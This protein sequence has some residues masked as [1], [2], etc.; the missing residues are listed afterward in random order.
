M[1][2]IL[3]YVYANP[4][5]RRPIDAFSQAVV[6]KSLRLLCNANRRFPDLFID[7]TTKPFCGPVSIWKAA[8]TCLEMLRMNLSYFVL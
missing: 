7:K 1:L 8:T 2:I 5:Q 3:D 6:R 4:D